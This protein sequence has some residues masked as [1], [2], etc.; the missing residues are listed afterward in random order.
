MAEAAISEAAQL[1]WANFRD[2]KQIDVLPASCRPTSR[3]EGYAAQAEVA[4]L[5]GQICL[6]WRIAVTGAARR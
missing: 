4:R 1:I 5:S 6:G 3:A 2:G